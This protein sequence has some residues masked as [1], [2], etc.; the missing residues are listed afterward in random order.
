MVL[1]HALTGLE[2]DGSGNAFAAQ[3]AYQSALSCLA[4][5]TDNLLRGDDPLVW[6]E[7]CRQVQAVLADRIQARRSST[8]TPE[9]GRQLI[10]VRFRADIPLR[11]SC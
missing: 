5:I 8:R 1:D 10:T 11:T 7:A 6:L 4:Y 3:L 9:H 2:M